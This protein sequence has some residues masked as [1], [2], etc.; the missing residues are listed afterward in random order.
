MSARG[1]ISALAMVVMALLASLIYLVTKDPLPP[2]ARQPDSLQSSNGFTR[3]GL[4]RP[5][6]TN[7]FLFPSGFN[8]ASL[9][10]TNYTTYIQ[11]LRAIGCPEE[12]IRDIII[13]DVAKLYAQ[14]RAR[15]WSAAESIPFWKSGD[16]LNAQMRQELRRLEGE[17]RSLIRELLG[18]DLDSHVERYSMEPPLRPVDLAFLPADKQIRLREIIQRSRRDQQGFRDRV[19]TVWTEL[20]NQQFRDLQ[21]AEDAE[22]RAALSPQEYAEYE[23]RESDLSAEL[24]EQLRGLNLTEAEFRRVFRARR[25]Y[26]QVEQTAGVDE[27]PGVRTQADQALEQELRDA[28]GADRWDQYQRAQE[29]SYQTLTK[30]AER[31]NMPATVAD[32]AYQYLHAAQAA[33]EKVMDDPSVN[34]SVREAMLQTMSEEAGVG[35]KNI[36]GPDGYSLFLGSGGKEWLNPQP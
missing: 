19:G 36:L 9:E 24:R 10:S 31:L 5:N 23:L 34:E 2:A 17:Q 22:I 27:M 29:P 7:F 18:T 3:V 33:M 16:S 12:T 6:G 26:A 30:L 35:L 25:A 8:W 14:Q 20:D 28:L 11:N 21:N 4:R 15:I 32:Q 13:A 1:I